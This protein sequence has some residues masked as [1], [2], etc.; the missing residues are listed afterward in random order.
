[1]RNRKFGA[2]VRGKHVDAFFDARL[3]ELLGGL[4][5]QRRRNVSL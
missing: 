2:F 3:R 1:M 5:G 4:N